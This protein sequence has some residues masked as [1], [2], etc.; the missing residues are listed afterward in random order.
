MTLP[1]RCLP[2]LVT[3]SLLTACAAPA[4]APAVRGLH[5]G[6]ITFSPCALSVPRVDAVEAQCARLRVPEN[7][8]APQGRQI[9]L[10]IAWIPA[11]GEAEADPIVM[12]AGGPGQSALESYPL[13][14]GAFADARRNRHV[15]LV[16]ARGT[17]GSHPLKCLDRA[18]KNAVMEEADETPE[19]ARAFAQRCRDRLE[20]TSDLRYYT[21]ADH[22]RDLDLV[23]SKLGA[24]TLNLVGISY[25][26]RVGQQYAKRFPARTRTLTLDAVAPNSLVLGQEHARN[27]E[28][29]LQ[30]QFA[31]CRVDDACRRNLGDPAQQLRVVRERLRAGGLPAV[32]YR[33]PTTGQWRSEVP[34]FG[35]L[36]MLLRM[37]A[38]Q[39][40]ATALLP[41]ILHDAAQGRYESLLAQSRMLA[42]DLSELIVHGMQLSV[43]CSEDNAD[44]S[45]DDADIDSALAACPSCSR[46]SSKAPMRKNSM[47]PACNGC[48]RRRRSPATMAGSR[49]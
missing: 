37:Y 13:V 22:V 30:Q 38:Y 5:Y 12:I 36:A 16:D 1:L 24:T 28:T 3:A 10:A 9:E 6:R 23:R 49:N 7:H 43:L 17:G 48:S 39:P 45:V 19:A 18:G 4:D 42:G 15:I 26:T 31:R 20:K 40:Q 46:S 33:D 21:T 34:E 11:K 25:G 35:H 8:D 27:L 2:W 44:L 14:H 47:P 32:R 29:A 41:L